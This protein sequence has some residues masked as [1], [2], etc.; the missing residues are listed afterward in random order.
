MNIA[1]KLV[2]VLAAL[3]L[4]VPQVYRIEN[5]ADTAMPSVEQVVPTSIDLFKVTNS[6]ADF[7]RQMRERRNTLGD[8]DDLMSFNRCYQFPEGLSINDL[9]FFANKENY[10]A[11][12]IKLHTAS[13]TEVQTRIIQEIIKF[14]DRLPTQKI[15][16][17]VHVFISQSPYFADNQERTMTVQYH[18]NQY[19][20]KPYNITNPDSIDEPL[21]INIVLLFAKYDK[22][23]AV[24]RRPRQDITVL[25]MGLETR[26]QKCKIECTHEN[27]L[28]C[29]CANKGTVG[30][31]P[32][33][34]AVCLGVN[35]SR[36]QQAIRADFVIGYKINKKFDPL[37]VAGAFA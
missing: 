22:R 27:K 12:Q 4:L 28:L 18:I 34:T 5:F 17:D 2:I 35:P 9:L 21:D 19:I 8:R 37:V 32:R 20:F 10:A 11:V 15:E 24:Y 26:D 30:G 33:N 14:K 31:P 25:L 29:G 3:L 16:G 6:Y 36:P 13:F 23:R 1:I 7:D